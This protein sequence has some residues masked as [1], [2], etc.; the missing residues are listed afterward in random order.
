MMSPLREL[1]GGVTPD[2]TRTAGNDHAHEQCPL[3]GAEGGE[4]R[5]ARYP[6]P[7]RAVHCFRDRAP[8]AALRA[9]A[10]EPS[11]LTRSSL[12]LDTSDA[13]DKSWRAVLA[14]LRR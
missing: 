2:T 8:C 13:S 3:S 9:S 11:R 6:C 12:S 7:A 5:R 10:L 4:S 1:E 14:L